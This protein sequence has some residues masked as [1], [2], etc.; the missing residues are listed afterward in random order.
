[1][2]IGLDRFQAGLPAV[3]VRS[4]PTDRLD[5]SKTS[6]GRMVSDKPKPSGISPG[7]TGE[8]WMAFKSPALEPPV[9]GRV[10]LK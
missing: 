7:R 8:K 10:D 6:T 1:M 9:W 4:T 3:L 5:Y 2:L